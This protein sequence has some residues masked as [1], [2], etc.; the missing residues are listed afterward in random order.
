MR[1]T[2]PSGDTHEMPWACWRPVTLS[3][4]TLAVKPSM[5]PI[6]RPTVPPA[7]VMARSAAPDTPAARCTITDTMSDAEAWVAVPGGAKP[8]ARG[9]RRAAPRAAAAARWSRDLAPPQLIPCAAVIYSSLS[10][11]QD[12]D[13]QCCPPR[14]VTI[15]MGCVPVDGP[16]ASLQNDPQGVAA[17]CR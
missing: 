4:G 10:E 6:W 9:A 15:R 7:L 14:R 3:A 11:G 5:M 1:R 8:P 2:A 17:A 13:G 16:D 12:C